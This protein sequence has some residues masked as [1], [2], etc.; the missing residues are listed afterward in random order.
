MVTPKDV[1]DYWIDEVGPP[2]WYRVDAAID[3]EIRRRFLGAWE[4]AAAGEKGLWLT[5]ARD[6]LAY[7]VLT[8]QFP[9]NMFRE[10]ARAFATD[11]QARMAAKLALARDW[12]RR[13]GPPERQFFYLPLMHAES[14]VD[15]E[16]AVRLIAER[17]PQGG[18]DNL[19][20]A[21]AHRDIIR[22]FGRFP[23]RNAALGR[24]TAPEE[25]VFLENGGYGAVLRALQ[26]EA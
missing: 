20:H 14:L 3:D 26:A 18:G 6:T 11:G 16:R 24:R 23:Y 1:L 4:A 13:I 8:D 2:G 17:M 5:D 7:I 9:R 22:R 15:Q 19:V 10:D 25:A 21:R 12:D